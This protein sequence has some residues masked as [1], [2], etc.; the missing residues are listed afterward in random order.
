MGI[1]CHV[2]S[3]WYDPM[4][5]LRSSTQFRRVL[6]SFQPDII[7][8]H[9][10]GA[11]LRCL[12]AGRKADWFTLHST[13]LTHNVAF[14]DVGWLRKFL[15]PW[16][17]NFFVLDSIASDYLQREFGIS[18]QSITKVPNGVDC[19]RFRPPSDE[20]RASARAQFNVM[21]NETFVVFVGRLHPVKQP[22]AVV[23][24]A[25]YARECGRQNLKFAIVGEGELGE[26]V[27]SAIEEKGL[28]DIFHLHGWMDPI[29]AYFAAD[30]TVMP[31]L[32]EGFGLV[33][34][35][36]IAAGC[37]VLRSRT[38]GSTHMIQEGVSGFECE[39]ET[40]S[41]VERLCE[42]LAHPD[43]LREMRPRARAFAL[44]RLDIVA[45]ARHVT[46]A[47]RSR[48][49]QRAVRN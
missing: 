43:K 27:R 12:M 33:G 29:S 39:T 6:K 15:S 42:I 8:V 24:A 32:Y 23:E 17:R 3:L 34:A 4:S 45:S 7:H 21:P 5:I 1:Q 47:Y 25:A 9:G 46:A 18:S 26:A 2:T 28:G 13:H 10:R 30:L 35:E 48:L 11:A 22:L 37:P 44:E 31:S 38:G 36:A 41:F 16:G 14:Y 20:E 40:Q 19:V 49:P